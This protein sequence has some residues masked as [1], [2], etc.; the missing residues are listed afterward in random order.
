MLDVKKMFY[1]IIDPKQ[2][3]DKIPEPLKSAIT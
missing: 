2:K 3:I 1:C